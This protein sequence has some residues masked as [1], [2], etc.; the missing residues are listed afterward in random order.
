MLTR[1]YNRSS[2]LRSKRTLASLKLTLPSTRKIERLNSKKFSLRL[3]RSLT[4]LRK[5]RQESSPSKLQI[6]R[7]LPK[8]TIFPYEN[9]MSGL[10][11]VQAVDSSKQSVAHADLV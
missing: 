9:L 10:L 11:T 5:Q 6:L 7:L 8:E 3:I 1:R 2:L 4:R